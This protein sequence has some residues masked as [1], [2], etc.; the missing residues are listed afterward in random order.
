MPESAAVRHC[1]E[2]AGFFSCRDVAIGD[3]RAH[4]AACPEPAA[5]RSGAKR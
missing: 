4:A 2:F 3:F 5:V 1:S